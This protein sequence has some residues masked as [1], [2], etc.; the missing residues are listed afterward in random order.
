MKIIAAFDLSL[1]ATGVAHHD[2]TTHRI[3]SSL[4]GPARLAELRDGVLLCASVDD[5]QLVVLEGQ[6]YAANGR[7]HSD[8]AGLHALVRVGLWERDITFIEIP[9]T[10]LKKCATGRGNAP[11]PDLRAELIKRTGMDIA[12]DNEVD[13]WWLRTIALHHYGHSELELPKLQRDAIEKIAW[14]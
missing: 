12:D 9:P 6:A 3:H 14:P 2:G 10:V 4:G 8:L 13:A 11:K 5:H 1:V 7:G